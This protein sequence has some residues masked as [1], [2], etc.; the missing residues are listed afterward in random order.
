[1]GYITLLPKKLLIVLLCYFL[2]KV[3]MCYVTFALLPKK[4]LLR[5]SPKVTN[6][7]TLL[8]FME[9]NVLCYFCVTVYGK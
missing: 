7:I 5:Y 4:L 3:I 2:W 6:C 9:S 8:L 1:M